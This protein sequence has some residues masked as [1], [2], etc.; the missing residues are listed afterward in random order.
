M[1]LDRKQPPG[2]FDIKALGEAMRPESLRKEAF[3]LSREERDYIAGHA[4]DSTKALAEEL[5]WSIGND[6]VAQ[7]VG[8]D[9]ARKIAALSNLLGDIGWERKYDA[10]GTRLAVRVNAW[11]LGELFPVAQLR[12]WLEEWQRQDNEALINAERALETWELDRRGTTLA[13][14]AGLRQAIAA[15]QTKLGTGAILLA[16]IEKWMACKE[17]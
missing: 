6:G 12:P 5:A 11:S 14:E 10:P 15:A 16:R 17:N 2:M 7:G 9:C 8:S 4:L 3:H 1:S 13:Y